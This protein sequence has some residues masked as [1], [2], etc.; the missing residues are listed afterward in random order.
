MLEELTT[1]EKFKLLTGHRYFQTRSIKRLG[2]K[3]F[4]MTDGPFGISMHSSFFRKN[5][6]FP[7]GIN[8]AATWNRELARQYG[9]AV[10]KEARSIGR[11][12]VLSP[13]MNI[14]RSPLNGR[15]FE[16]FSEDPFLTKEIAI[17]YI[18]GV[19]SQRVAAC[20][21]HFVANNQE[22]NR[23][24]VSAEIP[25]RAL[26]EIYLR[27]FK[28]VVEEAD[29]WAIMSSYNRV[30]SLYVHENSRLLKSL[31]IDSWGFSGFVM[32]DWWATSRGIRK[33]K[34]NPEI[35]PEKAIKAMLSL[36]MPVPYVYSEKRLSASYSE[37]KFTDREL[38][39][40]VKRL[41]RVFILT[42]M[43]EDK[44][45]LPKGERNTAAH[46]KLA[47]TMAEEGMVLLK[48]END[49]LPI[50]LDTISKIAVLG[51]NS[52]K[53]FGKLL[54]GGSSAVKPPHEITPLRGLRE[55][56]KGKVEVIDDPAEADVVLLFMGLNHDTDI[57]LVRDSGK[58]DSISYG[59]DAEGTD[60]KILEL[61]EEQ[62]ILINKIASINPNTI[63]ILIN[64]S[65]LAMGEWIDNVPAILEAWY[66]GMEGGRAIANV[67]FGEVN[68]S[69][70]LPL[71]FP[72]CIS[73]SPAHASSRTF[74]GEGLTVHYD[75]GI[76]VGYRYFDKKGIKPLFPFGHGLSYTTFDYLSIS[77]DKN[78]LNSMN[79]SLNVF[80][81]I[82]N[83]GSKSGSEIIQV[84]A[85]DI[86]SSVERPP[87]ELVGFTKVTLEPGENKIASIVIYGKSLA[88]Y[89]IQT[90]SWKVENG[91]FNIL[92]GSSSG[93]IHL[94]ERIVYDE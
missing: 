41:L 77:L 93:E 91:D 73:D 66:L 27:A 60:R 12:C 83:T 14:D 94:R 16:Y 29:P 24:T 51:P 39:A 57:N 6:R 8:L 21:K 89:D 2:I 85:E 45:A 33:P 42:G 56:C 67:I 84:Y 13:G 9:V 63:V 38:D 69:G 58:S 75:E 44:K 28:D 25:E 50:D 74:P 19:Q 52:D 4:K 5:T 65:P 40:V 70:K 61:P 79:D 87:K 55:K 78:T 59:N 90:R 76:H 92:V 30:N 26:H 23:F 43:F 64:G 17:P 82:T 47:L 11:S 71:T 37:G 7:A 49:L 35:E 31:L 1:G 53:K 48:N 10:G 22:T 54:Y 32:T 72:E 3:P 34:S 88:F 18:K 68:P 15:T 36:E 62:E 46:Q 80:I 81:E 20:P 86:E